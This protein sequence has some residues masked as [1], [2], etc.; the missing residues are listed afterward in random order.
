MSMLV[1]EM[2][3]KIRLFEHEIKNIQ[4]FVLWS[5]VLPSYITHHFCQK[6]HKKNRKNQQNCLY[7]FE[8]KSAFFLQTW[9]VILRH[10]F[11]D[12]LWEISSKPIQSRFILSRKI[13]KIKKSIFLSKNDKKRVFFASILQDPSSKFCRSALR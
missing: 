5:N 10:D 7:A 1:I 2:T 3:K 13:F 9:W 4:D 6:N 12:R 8:Q 11:A